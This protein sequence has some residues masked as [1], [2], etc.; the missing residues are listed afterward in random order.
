MYY[1]WERGFK[2]SVLIQQLC[3][4]EGCNF[5]L[6]TKEDD[7]NFFQ[8]VANSNSVAQFF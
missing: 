2:R 4:I 8:Y 3:G 6:F 5:L 1:R 7:K